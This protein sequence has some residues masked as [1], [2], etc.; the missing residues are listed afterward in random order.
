MDISFKKGKRDV[1]VYCAWGIF[2]LLVAANF[3]LN[4]MTT[5]T[6]VKKWFHRR[7][8]IRPHSAHPPMWEE[9]DTE[10]VHTD[11]HESWASY[12]CLHIIWTH[13]RIIKACSI[14]TWPCVFVWD[15]PLTCWVSSSCRCR[16]HVFAPRGQGCDDKSITPNSSMTQ[17]ICLNW[18]SQNPHL[19]RLE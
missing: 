19:Y 18:T 16:P 10:T 11:I 13:T 2:M 8:S 15:S 4:K 12:T 14:I 9:F 5:H 6:C 3:P 7:D 1:T 17:N